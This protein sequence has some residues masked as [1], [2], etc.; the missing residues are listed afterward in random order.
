M[1][2]RDYVTFRDA[3]PAPYRDT[4]EQWDAV[5]DRA[6]VPREI[7]RNRMRH[8]WALEPA[9]TTP[10]EWKRPVAARIREAVKRSPGIT[11]EGLRAALPDV[12]KAIIYKTVGRDVDAGRIRTVKVDGHNPDGWG[13]V[14]GYVMV[15]E[16]EQPKGRGRPQLDDAWTPGAWV[17]PIR[18][19][20]L[21]LPVA[22][23]QDDTP[24][25]Y[26]HPMRKVAA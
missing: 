2:D 26:A 25:D 7:V 10:K 23:R 16:T 21:G 6:V 22:Q 5:K 18:A 4:A 8:G 9:L 17:H 3:R 14:L 20:L 15:A 12:P 13:K 19:R 1:T 11:A 24:I